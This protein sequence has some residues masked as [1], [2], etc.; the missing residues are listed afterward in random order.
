MFKYSLIFLLAISIAGCKKDSAPGNPVIIP[1]VAVY[2][3]ASTGGNC[4]NSTVQGNYYMWNTLD[5]TNKVS[6]QVNV[7][8]A[9]TYSIS[10]VTQNNYRFTASGTFAATGLQTITLKASGTPGT[11]GVNTFPITA[12]SSACSFTVTVLDPSLNDNDNMYFGNPSNAALNTDS[13]NNYLMRKTYYALSYSSDRGTPNWVSWHLFGDDLGT[14]P[15]QDDFREDNTL[16]VGWYQVTSSS[17]SSTGFDRGHNAPS[18]DRTRTVE[19]NSSTFLMTNF[20]P[21]SPTVNQIPW[22][23]MEDSIRRLVSLGNEVYII[24]G[25]Y[26]VGGTGNNGY[27]TT[28]DGGRVTVPSRIWK[29]AVVI[30]DG[31]NDGSRVTTGTRIIA[32]DMPNTNTIGSN[33]KSYRVSVDAI[34]AVTGYDLLSRLPVSL[35]AILEAS[36]DNL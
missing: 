17:Y 22:E 24:M 9:G 4:D 28:I 30:P 35:Q 26:G 23:R 3:L 11:A 16:P 34:E 10:T 27:A 18:G 15:R 25:S 1:T 7:T 2:T 21:Q 14:T 36:I 32:V 13:T 12:G 5:A 31:N 8:T 29:I 19:A 6:L 33:W 20:I